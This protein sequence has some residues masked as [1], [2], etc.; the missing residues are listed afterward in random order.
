MAWKSW[1]KWAAIGSELG[2]LF[3]PGVFSKAA[4]KG[5]DKLREA[6]EER[7]K[8]EAEATKKDND[9]NVR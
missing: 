5:A 6:E 3:L 4:D 7:R 8:R 9:A 1:R 2:S